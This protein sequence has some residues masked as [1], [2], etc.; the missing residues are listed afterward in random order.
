MRWLFTGVALFRELDAR[1]SLRQRVKHR[2]RIL[3]RCGHAPQLDMLPL[4]RSSPA[5]SRGTS[6]T[7]SRAAVGLLWTAAGTSDVGEAGGCTASA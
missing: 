4:R 3:A 2:G 7:L 5:P 1:S 6:Q